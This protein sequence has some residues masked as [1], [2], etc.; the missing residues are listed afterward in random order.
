MNLTLT[1]LIKRH[2]GDARLPIVE[3]SLE[4]TAL[5]EDANFVEANNVDSHRYVQRVSN[6][7][8]AYT[9]V[10]MGVAPSA[11]G[12]D[13]K[14][15]AL[16]FLDSLAVIDEKFMEMADGGQSFKEDEVFN[17][18]NT[19]SEK[20]SYDFFYGLGNN[21]LRGLSTRDEFDA[22]ADTQVISADG[23]GAN[24]TSAYIVNWTDTYFAY[25][26]N[27]IGGINVYQ[28]GVDL[29]PD[30]LG[31]YYRAD[32]TMVSFS[33]GLVVANP[34]QIARVANIQLDSTSE[35]YW[36]HVQYA[37]V[38][39]INQLQNRN[40][41]IVIYVN[42][43]AASVLEKGQLSKGN[44]YFN[45]AGKIGGYGVGSFDGIPIKRVDLIKADEGLIS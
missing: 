30:G 25:P 43:Q 21:S 44:V 3:K 36:Q 26:K 8:P 9:G 17:H 20:I 5:F 13:K 11:S 4:Y 40:G 27:S 19:L 28:M 41:N 18:T 12:T 6:S 37:L 23:T 7:T 2:N 15:E 32:R 14:T 33:G 35:T 29:M 38:D 16:A 10:N 1:E 24:Q 42:R 45:A 39:G 34:R 31:G 22:I